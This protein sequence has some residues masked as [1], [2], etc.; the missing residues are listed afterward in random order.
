MH[1]V[2]ASGHDGFAPT[3]EPSTVLHAAPS[4]V[5]RPLIAIFG[6]TGVLPR[7]SVT[8]PEV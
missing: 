2:S 8:A 6:L 5:L 7:E 1:F 3:G 4:G